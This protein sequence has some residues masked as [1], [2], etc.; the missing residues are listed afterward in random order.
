MF[1]TPPLIGI[2]GGMG[3]QAGLDLANKIIA[4]TRSKCDQDHLP[5]VLFSLPATVPDRTAFL[6]GQ[7]DINPAHTIADQFERMSDLGVTIAAMACNT[8]HAPPIFD[9]AMDLLHKRG[10]W[11]R[12]LHM[13]EET[14]AH[15]RASFPGIQRVGI[16]GTKGTY[17]TRLYDQVLEDAGLEPVTPDRDIRE[18]LIHAALYSPLYGIKAHAE[19]VSGKASANIHSA[20]HHL[21]GLGAQAVI[22]GCTELPLAVK[23]DQVDGIPVLDP[24]RIIAEQLIRKT[25][26]NKISPTV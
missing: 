18:E 24:A 11:I 15:I 1:P 25:F 19:P 3:P 8:A 7:G 26:P 2:L 12:I 16:L 6:L 22:L 14:V 9:L 20:I 4:L 17:Q 21:H 23:E 13:V 10:V 5:F